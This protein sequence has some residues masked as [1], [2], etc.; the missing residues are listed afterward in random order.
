MSQREQISPSQTIVDRGSG[1]ADAIDRIK[2]AD[3]KL[4]NAMAY[5]IGIGNGLERIIY[6][7]IQT[8]KK[9]TWL[10]SDRAADRER[11]S[12]MEA[13]IAALE[14]QT[15]TKE[16]SHESTDHTTQRIA[17]GQRTAS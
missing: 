3:W 8:E 10:E 12:K 6:R 16:Q 17:R 14:V 4:A 11:L 5:R 7:L 9:I 1:F 2:D 13:R 15:Q